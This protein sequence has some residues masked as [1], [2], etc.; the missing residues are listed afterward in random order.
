MRAC[1]LWQTNYQ[2]RVWG[3]QV[4]RSRHSGIALR[5]RCCAQHTGIVSCGRH[6]MCQHVFTEKLIVSSRATLTDYIILLDITPRAVGTAR[7]SMRPLANELPAARAGLKRS[8]A[9]S[10]GYRTAYGDSLF[11]KHR[12]CQYLPTQKMMITPRAEITIS[13]FLPF[14][15]C[16]PQESGIKRKRL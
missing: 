16:P 2:R 14:G 11:G 1:V 12:M 10:F 5:R 4:L 6:R 15:Y 8:A 7:E 3:W 13:A 9:P